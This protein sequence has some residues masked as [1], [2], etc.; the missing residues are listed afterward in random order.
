MAAQKAIAPTFFPS[1]ATF[2]AWLQKHHAKSTEL[3]VGFYRKDSGKGGLTYSEALDQALCFGWI[4]G[5]R[6]PHDA[7]SY[8]TRFSPRKPRSIWSL[9]NVKRVQ[10][11][12]ALGL[13]EAAG[14][15]AFERR[16]AQ[17]TGVYSS[18]NR[19][20]ELS[21]SFLR[22]LKAHAA[23]WRDYSA[24]PPGYRRTAAFWVMSAKKEETRERRL[25]TLITCCAAG[26]TLPVLTSASREA[27]Q[28]ARRAT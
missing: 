21:A 7:R 11:L 17:R 10:A 28:R 3:H 16:T 26:R 2:R 4:D 19:H 1:S 15:A 9:V 6:L 25:R 12:Q 5:V 23:A 18:E 13:M 24:R 22:Q 8:I 20:V 27:K 14:T